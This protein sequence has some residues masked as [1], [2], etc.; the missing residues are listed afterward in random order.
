MMVVERTHERRCNLAAPNP[1]LAQ[2]TKMHLQEMQ[3]PNSSWSP[4]LYE[5]YAHFD[6]V[7]KFDVFILQMT[8][9]GI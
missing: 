3:K 2:G 4:M 6:F 9:K 1:I 8:K 5:H 7:W